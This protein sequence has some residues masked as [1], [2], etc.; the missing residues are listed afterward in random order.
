MAKIPKE[1]GMEWS[2]GPGTSQGHQDTKSREMPNSSIFENASVLEFRFRTWL[3][4][5]PG[6]S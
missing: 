1:E 2:S 6:G 4:G 5:F 3:P